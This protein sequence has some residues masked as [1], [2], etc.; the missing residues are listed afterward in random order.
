MDRSAVAVWIASRVPSAALVGET[1]VLS[2]VEN[3]EVSRRTT[4]VAWPSESL[5]D[6]VIVKVGAAVAPVVTGKEK[7][8]NEASFD[9]A[10]L[11][12]KWVTT[13]PNVTPVAV[14]A[15]LVGVDALSGVATHMTT[16]SPSRNSVEAPAAENVV[17][18]VVASD[19]VVVDATVMRSPVEE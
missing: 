17:P 18:V 19:P 5:F 14:I 13:V 16:T 2:A 1:S 8:A 4:N 6:V 10:V 12:L 9:D 15:G 7:I 11:T 3:L